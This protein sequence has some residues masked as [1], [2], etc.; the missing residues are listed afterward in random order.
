MR[1]GLVCHRGVGGSA[2]VAVDLARDLASRGHDVHLF[3][4]TAP[5]GIVG[6]V[7][8]QVHTLGTA[9]D[10]YAELDAAWHAEDR[11][12]LA[13]MIARVELDVLHYH[14]AVPFAAVT[15]A[16]TARLGSAAP[17]TV[18]TLHGTDVTAFGRRRSA[19]ALATLL[20]A[21]DALTTVSQSHARLATRLFSLARPPLVIPN[22]VCLE[23]F[24]TVAA[25]LPPAH[26]RRPRIAH[27]SNLRPVKRPGAM[28]RIFAEVRRCAEAE[29]WLVGDGDGRVAVDEIL[30]GADADRDVVRFGLR[31]DVEAILPHADA[32]LI[33]S[34]TESFGLAALEAAACALP[35]V[36]PRVG[37]LPDVVRDKV[38]GLLHRPGDDRAAV[39]ALVGL[40]ADPGIRV[41]MG[42][43]ARARATELSA[44]AVVPQ[45]E[46]LYAGLLA[47]GSTTNSDRPAMASQEA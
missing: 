44:A 5:F 43:A 20:S 8:L 42:M 22:F 47:A 46:E 40:L 26:G 24:S 38:T 18:G 36:A 1:I 45:Y 15:Q 29:L 10:A 11:E 17:V 28:A 30:R 34:R 35:V 21:T 4:R 33:T 39:R 9:E 2:R 7:G 6:G 23:R 12:A 41:R 37:G 13:E 27:V 14:Y 19:R 25:P 31:F 16:V 32:L 3:A